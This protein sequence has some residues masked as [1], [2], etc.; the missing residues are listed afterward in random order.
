MLFTQVSHMPGKRIGYIRCSSE[1]QNT[2]R[3]D[4]QLAGLDLDKIFTD[5]LSGKTLNRPALTQLL[6]YV[7]E[8]DLV[9]VT[10]MDRL[11]RNVVDLRNLVRQIT[12]IGASIEFK[13]ENLTFTDVDDSM[14]QLMLTMMGAVAEFEVA[15]LKERQREGIAIAVAKGDVYKGRVKSLKPAQVEEVKAQVASGIPKATVARNFGI[16]RKSIYNY[17]NGG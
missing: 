2:A 6:E 4:E 8:D 10:S 3:Q 16:S 7:R 9:I 12:D 17:L 5:K 11:A 15:L 13:K 14:S 1:S